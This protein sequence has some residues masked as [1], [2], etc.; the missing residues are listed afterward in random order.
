MSRLALVFAA[1][2]V[3]GSVSVSFAGEGSPD[4]AVPSKSTYYGANSGSS[5]SAVDN[6]WAERATRSGI[7]SN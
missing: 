3:A 5:M 6:A 7:D 4:F 2:L 1:A